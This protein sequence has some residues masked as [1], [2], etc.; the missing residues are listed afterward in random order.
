[1]T[2]FPTAVTR[3]FVEGALDDDGVLGKPGV[4]AVD[5]V[6][7]AAL[8]VGRLM[9]AGVG[10]RTATVPTT[11]VGL[12]LAALAGAEVGSATPPDTVGM[13]D[14]EIAVAS[15]PPGGAVDWGDGDDALDGV[16]LRVATGDEFAAI[17]VSVGVA[18]YAGGAGVLAQAA[19]IPR[20]TIA[21]D[22][23][24]QRSPSHRRRRPRASTS[25]RQ[26]RSRPPRRA[27]TSTS[28]YDASAS[29]TVR[30]TRSAASPTPSKATSRSGRVNINTDQCQR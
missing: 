13:G 5:G 12:G 10:L 2:E 14:G 23:D 25:A 6:A 7:A 24:P 30:I 3:C 27:G 28:R 4:R 26:A 21:V 19:E 18:R 15:A 16:T 17:A 29:A 8:G 11:D 1:M 20:A 22:A 9:T